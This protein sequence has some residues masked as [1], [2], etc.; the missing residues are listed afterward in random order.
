MVRK[1]RVEYEGAIYHVTVR[2]N[3]GANRFGDDPDRR[4]L[5]SRSKGHPED[6]K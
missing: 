4:C 1:L 3:G 5:L 2:S 6:S